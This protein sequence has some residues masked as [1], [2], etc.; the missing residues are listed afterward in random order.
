MSDLRVYFG[1]F[2]RQFYALEMSGNFCSHACAY[3]YANLNKPD[4]AANPTATLN[5]LKTAQDR[6]HKDL[7]ARLIVEKYPVVMSNHIDPFSNSNWRI[8][9]T[10]IDIFRAMK[11]P[12]GFQTR[13]AGKQSG[14]KDL[15]ND[16]ITDG[17]PKAFFVSITG[18]DEKTLRLLEPGA[19]S[20]KERLDL[21]E[22]LKAYNHPVIVAIAPYIPTWWRDIDAALRTIHSL[23]ADA[24][25]ITLLHFSLKQIANMTPKAHAHF[26]D[27][28]DKAKKHEEKNEPLFNEAERVRRT[29]KDIGLLVGSYS[30]NTYDNI[31][32]VFYPAYPKRFP[33]LYDFVDWCAQHKQHGDLIYWKDYRDFFLPKLPK[34][35]P[36]TYKL[37]SYIG[38]SSRQL[39]STYKVPAKMTYHQ[40]LQL[41]WKEYSVS[42]NPINQPPFLPLI[43]NGKFLTDD[44]NLPIFQY[45]PKSFTFGQD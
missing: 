22:K 12:F 24:V 8:Y 27:A 25:F 37:D 31:W 23:K 7:L 44:Q 35:Q 29:A 1:E 36:N 3:C 26:S 10:Y 5:V 14:A 39:W 4:R 19:P 11:I 20:Y 17:V 30:Q 38:A 33:T 34:L 43:E 28:I 15:L 16:V 13:G 6:Q 45:S 32:R 21:V 9:R 41:T 40:L 2:M 42:Y 18:D